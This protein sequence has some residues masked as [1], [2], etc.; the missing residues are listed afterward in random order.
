MGEALPATV[1]TPGGASAVGQLVRNVDVG[2]AP[3]IITGRGAA[4][5]SELAAALYSAQAPEGLGAAI[6]VTTADLAALPND[7]T[8]YVPETWP[9][10]L[11][12]TTA[13]QPCAVLHATSDGRARTTFATV[14]A[15][16]ALFAGRRVS[17]GPGG[18]ALVRSS[19][20]GTAAGPVF[21]IDQ[22]A[23]RFEVTN[24]SRE[25]LSRLGYP[26]VTPVRVPAAWLA[27]FRDGPELDAATARL[28]VSRTLTTGE[29]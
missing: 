29:S 28:A 27:Q 21:L 15:E 1:G 17:V 7:T 22:T 18:G 10:A 9:T 8:T 4:P 16:A 25:T 24:P 14:P 3:S 11:P 20:T 2:G 6:E 26:D 12:G 19:S 23:T 5:V 13:D